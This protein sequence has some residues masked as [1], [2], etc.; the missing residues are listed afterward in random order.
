MWY[1]THGAHRIR[2]NACTDIAN[3][4]LLSWRQKLSGGLTETNHCTR[5]EYMLAKLS[6]FVKTVRENERICPGSFFFFRLHWT[7]VIRWSFLLR[8]A[9]LRLFCANFSETPKTLQPVHSSQ[10]VLGV[11]FSKASVG[12][13]TVVMTML[14]KPS[15]RH[16]ERHKR[17]QLQSPAFLWKKHF[18]KKTTL[19]SKVNRNSQI[20]RF[21]LLF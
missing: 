6:F 10:L 8:W 11:L 1:K 2:S 15:A 14:G 18:K 12:A 19:P 17:H 13:H 20:K 7:L 9:C 5:R 21:F 3:P 16:V 4:L